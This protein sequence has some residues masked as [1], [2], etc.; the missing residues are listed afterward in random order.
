MAASAAEWDAKYRAAES[1]AP[2]QAADFVQ[3]LLPLLPLGRA[4]DVACGTGRHTLLL[5]SRKQ[6]VTAVDASSVA[7]EILERRAAE[8]HCT[9]THVRQSAAAPPALP[10]QGQ[11]IQIWRADLERTELPANFFSLI[12]CVN[13]LQ[14]SL[15]AQMERALGAGGVLLFET[16]TRAQLE[17]AGG[18]RNTEYLLESGELRTAFPGLRILFYREL[19]AGK[20]I[21]SLIARKRS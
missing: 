2:P 10:K 9:V 13:Y 3:E 18:P 14:R 16:F 21:A 6:P 11:G 19:R 12:I 1:E 7:L 20:G 17:F 8:S 4:L 15:F 5:A